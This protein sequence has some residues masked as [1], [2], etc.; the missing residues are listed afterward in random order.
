MKLKEE[1]NLK[2]SYDEKIKEITGKEI[3]EFITLSSTKDGFCF[4][5]DKEFTY[6]LKED[7]KRNYN[8]LNLEI[9]FEKYI[10]DLK[11]IGFENNV[12]KFIKEDNNFYYFESNYGYSDIT[13][14]TVKIDFLKEKL[15]EIKINND[16][17]NPI[18]LEPYYINNEL[19]FKLFDLF[20][21]SYNTELTRF[22]HF[23]L[24]NEN[25]SEIN[26]FILSKKDD[27]Y[28]KQI[29]ANYNTVKIIE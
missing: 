3:N 28:I 4:F 1:I 11:N 22:N 21:L 10:E 27:N 2:T 15:S 20:C 13:M 5:Y 29:S 17:L 12:S 25:S 9:S 24:S 23:I 16:K 14:D 7:I 8:E 19:D 18:S 26:I 6:F